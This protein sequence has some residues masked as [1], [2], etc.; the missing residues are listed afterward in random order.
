MM[1]PLLARLISWEVL[2]EVGGIPEKIF[3]AKICGCKKVFI[4]LQ[5]YNKLDEELKRDI[6]CKIIPVKH[7]QEIIE[8]IYPDLKE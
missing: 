4:P 1:W 2:F 3:A 5:N 7:V 6:S 8:E